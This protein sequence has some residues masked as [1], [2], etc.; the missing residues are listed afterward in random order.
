MKHI[1]AVSK[2]ERTYNTHA[3]GTRCK[4]VIVLRGLPGLGK[5]SLSNY[6]IDLAPFSQI[7]ADLA[8]KTVTAHLGFDAADRVTQAKVMG[9]MA[10]WLLTTCQGTTPVVDFV[11]PTQEAH[12]AFAEALGTDEFYLVNMLAE[13]GFSC[14]FPDTA[15]LFE[16][17]IAHPASRT[18]TLNLTLKSSLP[19]VADLIHAAWTKANKGK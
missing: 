12:D 18:L 13:E 7:N 17:H 5:T 11:M 2:T 8:R 1:Q 4:K 19:E 15:K 14:R 16:P 10:R 3:V 9:Y 6:L